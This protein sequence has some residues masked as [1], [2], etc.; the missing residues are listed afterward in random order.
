MASLLK[1]HTDLD[2]ARA[3]IISSTRSA[4]NGLSKCHILR[5]TNLS[6]IF[7][8]K[9]SMKDTLK[10]LEDLREVQELDG[11]Y[12]IP[13]PPKSV[14]INDEWLISSPIPTSQ[15]SPELVFLEN[16]GFARLTRN[17]LLNGLVQ[18]LEDWMGMPNCLCA[19]I[20]DEIDFAKSKLKQTTLNKNDL[21]FYLPW[22]AQK[23]ANWLS[24]TELTSL[25][26][27]SLFLGRSL[28]GGV[29]KYYWCGFDG[30]VLQESL[31]NFP[32]HEL[33]KIQFALEILHDSAWR[34]LRINYMKNECSFICPFILPK[35]IERLLTA[36]GRKT[37]KDERQQVTY[38]ISS[39]HVELISQQFANLHIRFG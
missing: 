16:I 32:K 1:K 20:L 25:S 23:N 38:V 6:R 14:K 34:V 10:T 2:I 37:T 11:G 22:Y 8:M 7:G 31:I 19:W 21:E 26:R 15:L 17:S 3:V 30:D 18:R 29:S 36:I 27:D 13:A 24:V 28:A 33:I 9:G 35:E 5:L 12:W 4:L 39:R